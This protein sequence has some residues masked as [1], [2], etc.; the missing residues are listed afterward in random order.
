MLLV[1]IV[2]SGNTADCRYGDC[3]LATGCYGVHQKLGQEEIV[4]KL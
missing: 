4:M 1:V 2:L 3:S